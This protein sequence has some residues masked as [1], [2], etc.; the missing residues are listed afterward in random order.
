MNVCEC[1]V[2]ADYDAIPPQ[3]FISDNE[4]GGYIIIVRI[5]NLSNM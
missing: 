4:H 1:S 2:C 5:N 3:L